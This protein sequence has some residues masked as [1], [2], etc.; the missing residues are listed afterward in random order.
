MRSRASFR[1]HPIHPALIP[2]PFAF[3][4]GSFLFDLL[5]WLTESVPLS[6]T[7]SH[8]VLAGLATA[9]IAA[10]PG[11]VDYFYTVP[12]RSS[13]KRR[14]RAHALANITALLLFALAWM[15]RGRD[16]FP[17]HVSLLLQMVGTGALAYA[18]WQGGMLVTRNMISVD[19]RHAQAGKWREVTVPPGSSDPIVAANDELETGQMK[20]IRRGDK[21]VVL[22]RTADGY[23][24]FDDRCSHRGGSLA[25]GVLIGGTVQCLWHGSQFDCASG[26]VVCGPAKKPIG[27]YGV[28]ERRDGI[29]VQFGD[30]EKAPRSSPS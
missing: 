11:T 4:I 25:D 1:S 7:A 17:S 29:A 27:T 9:L 26:R 30:H 6:R 3:L 21:R 20:L 19:H 23:L 18:G 16:A 13:G 14:A 28:T 5:G 10:I 12:P 22:A 24:A 8:L 15:V 2:F